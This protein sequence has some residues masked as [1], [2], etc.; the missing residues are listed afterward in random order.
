MIK[1]LYRFLFGNPMI[2]VSDPKG[3]L[4]EEAMNAIRK[5]YEAFYETNGVT[6]RRL[7]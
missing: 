5:D 1:R 3:M 7:K 4:P 2:I 6:I